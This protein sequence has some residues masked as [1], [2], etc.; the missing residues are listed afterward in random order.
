MNYLHIHAITNILTT[1]ELE[2]VIYKMQFRLHLETVNITVTLFNTAFTNNNQLSMITISCCLNSHRI[3]TDKLSPVSE[4]ITIS[5][6]IF[7][8]VSVPAGTN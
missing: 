7:K 4:L 2:S 1:T 8:A 6:S 5:I 3:T